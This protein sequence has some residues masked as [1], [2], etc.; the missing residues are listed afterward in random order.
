[1]AGNGDMYLRIG[2]LNGILALV[3]DEDGNYLSKLL[4]EEKYQLID[5]MGRG[6]DGNIYAVLQDEEGHPLL[7]RLDGREGAVS[8]I[9]EDILPGGMG[10]FACVGAGTDSDLILYGPGAGI[11]AYDLGEKEVK[12]HIPAAELP[13]PMDS[14]CKSTVL[15]D[16]RMLFAER[17]IVTKDAQILS[18][19]EGTTF[20]YIPFGQ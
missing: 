19:A 3:F 15:P 6:R 17:G 16:G 12:R 1:M 14:G 7:A 11:F 5:A 18:T 8:D 20:Y 2:G 10:M 13:F 4:D 9:R